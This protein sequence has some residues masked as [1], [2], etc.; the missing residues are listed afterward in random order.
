MGFFKDLFG[1]REPC[2]LCCLGQSSWPS[3]RSGEA[4]WKLRGHGLQAELL[5]CGQCRQFLQETGLHEKTPMLA[6]AHLV[7]AGRAERP[8]VPAYLQHPEWRKIWLHLLDQ[9]GLEPSDEFEALQMMKPL[10]EKFMSR[11]QASS[12]GSADQPIS[13]QGPEGLELDAGLRRMMEEHGLSEEYI[14][15]KY[16]AYAV[17]LHA[18]DQGTGWNNDIDDYAREI[19]A[20]TEEEIRAAWTDRHQAILNRVKVALVSEGCVRF[21]TEG[22]G[23]EA[24]IHS[25]SQE[26]QE[27][28]EPDGGIPDPFPEKI[29]VPGNRAGLK[30]PAVNL[31]EA[32]FGRIRT[33]L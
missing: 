19:G 5:I 14:R 11:G 32:R 30:V 28:A 8:P 27:Q 10:E 22:D 16:V 25:G 24:D 7:A 29:E 2:A 33:A 21:S 4:D 3:K 20:L 18:M 23:R 26:A 6:L 31:E 9:G 15:R 1:P 13:P 17:S 12:G